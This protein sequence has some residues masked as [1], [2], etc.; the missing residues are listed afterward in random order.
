MRADPTNPVNRASFWLEDLKF[1]DGPREIEILGPD[2][3]DAQL[4]VLIRDLDLVDYVTAKQVR[5]AI[6]FYGESFSRQLN[7]RSVVA[8]AIFL[9]GMMHGLALAARKDADPI[10][11]RE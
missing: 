11:D 10:Y 8:R 5:D 1:G 3:L 9:D 2:E 7:T 4:G 6:D